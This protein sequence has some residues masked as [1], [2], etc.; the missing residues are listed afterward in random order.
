MVKYFPFKPSKICAYCGTV[1]TQEGKPVHLT[2]EEWM[3]MDKE[4]LDSFGCKRCG[5]ILSSQEQIM[6]HIYHEEED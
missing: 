4:A 5:E 2:N 6:N 1:Y 3:V